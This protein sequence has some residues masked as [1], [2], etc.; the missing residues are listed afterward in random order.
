MT[1]Y[2]ESGDSD[3]S[4]RFVYNGANWISSNYVANAW[5]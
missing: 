2:V 5:F 1:K 4:A 3:A